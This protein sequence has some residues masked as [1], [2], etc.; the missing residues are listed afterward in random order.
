M[1][2]TCRGAAVA[3][4]CRTCDGRVIPKHQSCGQG[5]IDR[6]PSAPSRARSS[7]LQGHRAN[8]RSQ[9]PQVTATENRFLSRGAWRSCLGNAGLQ[10]SIFE[11]EGRPGGSCPVWG[12]GDVFSAEGRDPGTLHP[13]RARWRP[14]APAPPAR[15]HAAHLDHLYLLANYLRFLLG[16][17]ASAYPPP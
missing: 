16:S 8:A 14:R 10:V 7:R 13:P 9:V 4:T 5:G 2:P 3:A 1:F 15:T 6:L 11:A 17:A 12:L